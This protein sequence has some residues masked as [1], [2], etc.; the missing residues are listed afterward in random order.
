MALIRGRHRIRYLIKA[1]RD[2]NIQAFIR[3]WLKGVPVP[4]SVRVN[5]DIDPYSFM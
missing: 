1:P 2:F 5:V 4:A 3:A